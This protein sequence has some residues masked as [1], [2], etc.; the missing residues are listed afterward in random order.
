MV[1]IRDLKTQEKMPG[2]ELGDIGPKLGQ[3]SNDNGWL[4][5]TNVRI[6]RENMLSRFMQVEKGGNNVTTLPPMLRKLAYAGMLNLRVVMGR[7]FAYET[8]VCALNLYDAAKKMEKFSAFSKIMTEEACTAYSMAISNFFASYKFINL[9][10]KLHH[11]ISIKK[12]DKEFDNLLKELHILSSAFKAQ[13]SYECVKLNSNINRMISL[14]ALCLNGNIWK[15]NNFVPG[16]TYEGDNSV[17]LQQTAREILKMFNNIEDAKGVNS[18]HYFGEW[19]DR[20]ASGKAEDYL[21]NLKKKLDDQNSLI[22]ILEYSHFLDTK[23]IAERLVQVVGNQGL[24]FA[25]AWNETLQKEVIQNSLLYIWVYRL[26]CFRDEFQNMKELG[27]LLEHETALRDIFWVSIHY[28]FT[29]FRE[30]L[31]RN[32]SFDSAILQS[33]E[34]HRRIITDRVLQNKDAIFNCLDIYPSNKMATQDLTNLPFEP[35]FQDNLTTISE[36]IA[37]LHEEIGKASRL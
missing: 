34:A 12:L 30:F 28:T 16:L 1:P 19:S 37:A 2:V 10:T 32:V 21:Q 31:I 25:R 15:Y 27:V 13:Y 9:L 33:L 3:R 23:R 20:I 4:R 35:N 6:P 7:V 5:L 22:E 24:P 26:K 11:W 29:E 8:A 17:L 14:G 18:F 36:P